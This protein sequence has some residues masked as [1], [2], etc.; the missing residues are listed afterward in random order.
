MV[1]HNPELAKTY[2]PRIAS[3]DGNILSDS[4]HTNKS[5]ESKQGTFIHEDEDEFMTALNSII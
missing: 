4:N 2:P 5:E 3:I 1:T